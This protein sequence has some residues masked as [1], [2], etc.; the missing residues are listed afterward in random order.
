MSDPSFQ[1]KSV[2][3]SFLALAG[4]SVYYFA[5]VFGMYRSEAG[6]DTDRVG[7]LGISLLVGLIVIEIVYH[8]VIAGSSGS[9]ESDERDHWI[10][11]RA[12]RNAYIAL[13]IG[14]F[15]LVVHLL[16]GEAWGSPPYPEAVAPFG[17]A[18]LLLLALVL[19]E[20][21]KYISQI[22]YYRAGA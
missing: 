19:A 3:G 22:V 13:G 14:T 16:V 12:S 18:N 11:T 4:F 20:L 1:E 6:V 21:V 9:A 17:M 10:E 2:W 7:D 15:A 8:A 5:S